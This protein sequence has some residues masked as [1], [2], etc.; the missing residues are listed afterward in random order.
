MAGVRALSLCH[1][2]SP[3]LSLLTDPEDYTEM[4]KKNAPP[5]EPLQRKLEAEEVAA[6]R[7]I[8]EKELKD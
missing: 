8:E 4:A 2:S 7:K 6:K 1:K 5:K 3:Q